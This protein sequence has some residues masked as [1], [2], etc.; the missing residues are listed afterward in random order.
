MA[1]KHH[2]LYHKTRTVTIH[3]FASFIIINMILDIVR[4]RA[5]NWNFIEIDP[6]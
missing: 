3:V 1:R 2:T 5:F 6:I 4:N